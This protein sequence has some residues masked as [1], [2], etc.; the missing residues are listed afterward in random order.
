MENLD[1][2]NDP[3]EEMGV[4]SNQMKPLV[5]RKRITKCGK[6]ISARLEKISQPHPRTI[7]SLY[8]DFGYI[9]EPK[10]ATRIK[11]KIDY[12]DTLTLE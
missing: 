5:K 4:E 6:N 11:R 7:V 9:L 2:Y 10:R 1:F 12:F 8:N 3:T